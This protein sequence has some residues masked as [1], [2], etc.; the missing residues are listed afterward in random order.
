MKDDSEGKSLPTFIKSPI[1][2]LTPQLA[3]FGISALTR[4]SFFLW[5]KGSGTQS[6]GSQTW[7]MSA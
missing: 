7:G 6:S 2:I 4:P 5:E 3:P 1:I